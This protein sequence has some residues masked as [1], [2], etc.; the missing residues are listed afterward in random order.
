M[1]PSPS[2]IA[3]QTPRRVYRRD[4]VAEAV[5]RAGGGAVL[6]A[7]LGICIYLVSVVLPLFNAGA[8]GART[9]QTIPDAADVVAA[10][11]DEYN[12][13]ILLLGANGD[14]RA[15]HIASG[16]PLGRFRFAA[17][18]QTPSAISPWS[19]DGRIAL[20]YPDG[21]IQVGAIRFRSRLRVP[22]DSERDIPIGG[23]R[24]AAGPAEDGWT[25]VV[26][27]VG[28]EQVR[29]TA[30]ALEF[31][32]PAMLKVGAG[33]VRRI[34]AFADDRSEFVV[35]VRE[36][37]PASYSLLRVI[38]PLGGG[39]PRLSV[40]AFPFEIEGQD[41]R[42]DWLF[43][44]GDGKHVFALWKSGLCQRYAAANPKDEP[45]ALAEAI[46]LSEHTLTAATML[47]GSRTI[48]VADEAGSV[49][50]W[51]AAPD[52]A[53]GT[54]DQQRL[55][56]GH[57]FTGPGSAVTSIATS[58]RDRSV[59]LGDRLGAASLRHVSSE[60]S[61]LRVPAPTPSPVIATAIAP[62]NDAIAILHLDGTLLQ[63]AYSP[64]YPEIT[65]RSLFA[66]MHYEGQP[67]AQF[68]YQSSAGDDAAEAKLSLTPLVFGT[69]KATVV[70]M[71]FACPLAVFAAIYSSEFL[72]PKL[73]RKVKP[74][75]EIMASLPPSCSGS[76]PR[77]SS[78]PSHARRSRPCSWPRSYSRS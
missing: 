2:R 64:G 57:M 45:I 26:E 25:P 8:L 21:S 65:L 54:P 67:D 10:Q 6:I 19:R 5:I 39:P 24:P 34:G 9:S 52:P 37:G 18:D 69:L 22:D 40:S 55:V 11:L 72:A 15:F 76:S 30:P 3:R 38:K 13:A 31:S 66:P 56:R 14:L 36:E 59:L 74:A 32:Q 29:E 44:T 35:A 50:A 51:F 77:W 16:A 58:W 46:Q 71:L 62:K 17:K 53:A 78:H 42:P 33:A 1:P 43:V 20:G 7:V 47:L 4:R 12:Q 23:S 75:I 41:H 60:K 49:Q 61:I 63:A 73:R 28:A 70:A 27:R 68:V 48:V